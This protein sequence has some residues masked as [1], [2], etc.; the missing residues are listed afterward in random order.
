MEKVTSTS[1][2]PQAVVEKKIGSTP[3][4]SEMRDIQRQQDLMSQREEEERIFTWQQKFFSQVSSLK[5]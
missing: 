3:G 5:F 1:I 4:G 2:V